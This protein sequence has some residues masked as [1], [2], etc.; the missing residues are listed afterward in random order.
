MMFDSKPAIEQDSQRLTRRVFL[1][2]AMAAAGGVGLL[3]IRHPRQ[4]FADDIPPHSVGPVVVVLFSDNGK[5]LQ[6]TTMAKVVKSASEWQKQLPR[7]VYDITRLADT[8]IAYSGA[9]WNQHQRGLYRCICCDTAAFSSDTKFESGTGWPSFWAP[10]AKENIVETHDTSLGMD[11]T[12]VSCRLCDAHLGHVFTDGP[13]P[14][15]L[16]YCMNSA[17]LRFIPHSA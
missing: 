16:R 15:G 4:A 5:R 2:T 9:L 1:A 10:I 11:R 12:A 7:N 17:S 13:H 3:F 6:K 8:E 14:T